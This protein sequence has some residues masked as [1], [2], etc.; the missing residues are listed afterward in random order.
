MPNRAPKIPAER[1][2]SAADG[3]PAVAGASV[4]QSAPESFT[5]MTIDSPPPVEDPKTNIIADPQAQIAELKASERAS[6]SKKFEPAQGKGKPKARNWPRP[7]PSVEGEHAS[8]PEPQEAAENQENK[9]HDVSGET[10]ENMPARVAHYELIRELGRGGMGR[11][12]LARDTKLGRRVAIKFI[13][14]PSERFIAEARATAA[15]THENIVVIHEVDTFRNQPYMVLEYVEGH[16]LTK[17]LKSG[18]V[19]PARV[20]EICSAV[21]RGLKRAHDL[22]IVHRDL[23]F[24]NILITNDGQVKILDF[25]LAKPVTATSLVRSPKFE[26]VSTTADSNL[27]QEGRFIG[28]PPYMAP[29]QFGF[30]EVDHRTDIYALGIIMYRLLSGRHPLSKLSIDS[31]W[32]NAAELDVK[33]PSLSTVAPHVPPALCDIVDKALSKVK[34]KRW[35]DCGLLLDALHQVR[36]EQVGRQLEEGECP[37]PGLTSFSEADAN[38]FFGRARDIERV[39]TR[40]RRRPL[41]AVAG[42]SGAGKSSVIRAGVV[43]ALRSSG[44]KWQWVSL[45]PGRDPLKALAQVLDGGMGDSRSTVDKLRQEAGFFGATLRARARQ[46]GGRLVIFVDQFE[47]LYTLSDDVEAR[48]QFTAALAG[49]ADDSS[50][51]LRVIVSMRSDFLDR[52]AQDDREFAEEF[53]RGVMLLPPPDRDGLRQALEQPLNLVGYKFE[54]AKTVEAMLDQLQNTPGALP[55]LQFAASKLWEMRDTRSRV[56]THEAYEQI[57]GIAGALSQHADETLSSLSASAKKMARELFLRLVTPERT[58]AIVDLSELQDI[59]NDP[60]EVRRLVSL[61]VDAR[62][63]V[64]QSRGKSESPAIEIVHESL[65]TS[66]SA[67]R[68]WLDES[69][70]DAVFVQQLGQIAKQWDERKR[71]EGLLW[72]GETAQEA[73]RWLKRTDQERLTGRERAFM[74]AVL[75]LS[76]RSARRK[77]AFLAAVFGA[78]ALVAAGTGAAAFMIA[79]AEKT[80]QAQAERAQQEADKARAAEAVA[81]RELTLK[82]E[83][84]L[85]RD[86]ALKKLADTNTEL[87][88]RKTELEDKQKTLEAQSIELQMALDESRNL[89]KKEQASRQALEK[90]LKEKEAEIK[91]LA[92]ERERIIERLK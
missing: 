3:A 7:T 14:T 80:A 28:T 48:R 17:L 79:E 32:E 11:V 13:T 18:P 31:L 47:E 6:T 53:T 54:S 74:Q 26:E 77:R 16:P 21:A 62:L 73:L 4:S 45:R 40:L 58:R 90:L 61:F 24:D 66:W 76:T 69:H 35:S 36:P 89:A 25:G 12:Y 63:L 60:T 92:K 71:P 67:L 59:G 75:D 20:I 34:S 5:A 42:P 50:S 68:W 38:R 37:F 43:P 87:L 10:M 56:V 1:L 9:S 82:Q 91:R 27:T 81:K 23:K 85:E 15:C 78:M 64:V 52:V 86:G 29:E 46:D 19:A 41:V 65:I 70:E 22:G 30:G 2:V 57:G 49:A 84:T 39:M 55:L 51:P 33:L 72:R 83:R 8:D 88:A 44:E